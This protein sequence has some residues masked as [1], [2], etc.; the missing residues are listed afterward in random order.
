[1]TTDHTHGLSVQH[2]DR[3]W[4]AVAIPG[5]KTPTFTEQHE[6]VCAAVAE[7]IDEVTA[8]GEQPEQAA[9][10]DR[11]AQAILA[12]IKRATVSKAQ[13]FD[14]AT[15]LLAPNEFDLADVVL[16]VLPPP[17]SRA[18]VYGE[19]AELVRSMAPE[20]PRNAA[21][22][23]DCHHIADRIDEARPLLRRMADEAQPGP[24]RLK[25]RVV[26]VTQ[27]PALLGTPDDEIAALAAGEAQ[28]GT[29]AACTCGA[30]ACES[31]ACDC[32]SAPCPVNHAAEAR[33]DAPWTTDGAR[34]GRVLIWSHADIGKGD[35]GRGYRAA[36]E[37]ARAILTRPLL[38]AAEPQQDGAQQ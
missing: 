33:P 11:I 26:A 28:P 5:P 32:D 21:W 27:S 15:A 16:A 13:P 24:R 12:R 6:R 25:G 23:Q 7:I 29:E 17:V 30:T 36:Q 8:V 14:A 22:V 18:D 31:D 1:M 34:I 9:L 3:L 4:D 38:T 19:V 35:F 2:A 37:E 10:R 20:H